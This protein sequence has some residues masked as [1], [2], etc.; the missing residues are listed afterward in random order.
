M[1]EAGGAAVRVA[2]TVTARH[3]GTATCIEVDE[4]AQVEKEMVVPRLNADLSAHADIGSAAQVP[5]VANSGLSSVGYWLVGAGFRVEPDEGAWLLALDGSHQGL[6]RP[7]YNG[8]DLTA[9]PRGI[10]AIDFGLR[11]ENEAAGFPVLYNLLRDRVKSQREANN[12][13]SARER[14]WRFGRN[15]E[16]LRSALRH[17]CVRYPCP[18][19]VVRAQRTG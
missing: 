11:D 10:Y 5:L 12:D 16:D 4:R 17:I 14:W 7:I 18:T 19:S 15:R 3:P 8:R 13:R 1:D 6:V 2:R 9:R